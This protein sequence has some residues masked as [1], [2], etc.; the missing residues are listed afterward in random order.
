MTEAQAKKI[1]EKYNPAD[2][3]ARCPKGRAK[4]RKPLDLYAKAAVNLYGIITLS[5]LAEIFNAQNDERTTAGEIYTILLPNALKN[6]WYG[7]YKDYI[8]HYAVLR[9]FDWVRFLEQAQAGKPRY[10]PEKEKFLRYQWE[11]YNDGGHWL[12]VLK[13]MQDVF[14]YRKGIVNAFDEIR[15]YLTH[16][17]DFNKMYSILEEYGFVFHDSEESKKIFTL[18][19]SA[20]N[21]TRIWENKGHTP[22]ELYTINQKERLSKPREVAI[23]RPKKPGPNEPCPCGSGRKYKH[24]CGRIAESGSAQLSFSESKFFYETWYKLLDFVNRKYGIL[25]ITIDPVYPSYH[26]E[27][28]LHKIRERLWVDPKVIT[29]FTGSGSTLSKEETGLLLSW[30]KSH[31]K[32]LFML[33]RY[34]PDGA[35][36]MRTDKG[37]ESRLYAVKGMTVSIAEAMGR[38]LPVMLETVLLPFNDKIIYDSFMASYDIGFGKNIKSSLD[39]EYDEA[40]EKYGLVSTL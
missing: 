35:V 33:M 1:F 29:E 2:G 34:E 37:K 24:C 39:E 27:T 9:N 21:N 7:F 20:K 3:V 22:E 31:I 8:V 36:L 13:F 19:V 23:N 32:G 14:G 12:K 18:I 30:E 26:D 40:R 5:E 16:N 25:N 11:E 28:Q 15:N 17:D 10:I 4:M 38:R 6:G